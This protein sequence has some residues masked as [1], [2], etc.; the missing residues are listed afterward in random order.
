M[1]TL[2]A[3]P[4]CGAH[5]CGAP[6]GTTATPQQDA[7][8]KDLELLFLRTVNVLR[9]QEG[10]GAQLEVQHRERT[11]GLFARPHERDPLPGDRVL[12]HVTD[13]DHHRKV[14]G[15]G[16]AR[17]TD[18]GLPQGTALQEAIQAPTL[19]DHMGL[20]AATASVMHPPEPAPSA[21]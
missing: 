15:A 12:D 10:R 17:Q 20:T 19:D 14:A 21:L 6:A 9:R 2:A 5:A 8:L 18:A 4:P 3:A 16:H 11:T 13:I 1:R 7:A